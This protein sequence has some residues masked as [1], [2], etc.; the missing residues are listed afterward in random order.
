VIPIDWCHGAEISGTVINRPVSLYPE[1]DVSRRQSR[2]SALTW[3]LH[4]VT[5][6]FSM[7]DFHVF[8]GLKSENVDTATGATPLGVW[9]CKTSWSGPSEP[10][11]IPTIHG[12]I[13]PRLVFVLVIPA[14]GPCGASPTRPGCADLHG[15]SHD[16]R[17]AFSVEV[18]RH[19]LYRSLVISNH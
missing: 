6:P 3:T 13:G 2:I 14:L 5:L 18:K 12:W 4:I 8:G 1:T 11:T 10:I 15:G 16:I 9:L 7:P 17:A 19:R